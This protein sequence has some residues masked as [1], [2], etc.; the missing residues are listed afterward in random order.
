MCVKR[1]VGWRS[2]VEGRAKRIKRAAPRSYRCAAARM[3]SRRDLQRRYD[4]DMGDSGPRMRN[5][6]TGA[7][8]APKSVSHQARSR[9]QVVGE[10]PL[11]A[12]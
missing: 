9:A 2:S 5:K 10:G 3:D 1:A 6:G 11:G 12:H 8:P 7:E 4:R